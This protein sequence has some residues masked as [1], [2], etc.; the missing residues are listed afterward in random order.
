MGEEKIVELT[1][2]IREY[3]I[4]EAWRLKRE[5]EVD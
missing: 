2:K 3:S 1:G 4:I 5:A